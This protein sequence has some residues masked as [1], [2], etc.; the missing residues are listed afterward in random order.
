MIEFLGIDIAYILELVIANLL[1]FG[2]GAIVGVA[3][4]KRVVGGIVQGFA[5]N[6]KRN[7]LPANAKKNPLLALLKVILGLFGV[8]TT[9]LDAIEPILSAL[10]SPQQETK[11]QVW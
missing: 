4:V 2:L 3:I 11:G 10:P 5:E 1:T 7:A 6:A 9:V 8:D